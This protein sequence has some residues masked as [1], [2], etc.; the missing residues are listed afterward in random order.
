MPLFE[1][2]AVI[3]KC[4]CLYGKLLKPEDY[5]NLLKCQ[6]VSDIAVYLHDKTVYGEITGS[7]D[8]KKINR[9]KLEY[10]IKKSMLDDYLKMYRF[11]NG[12]QRHFIN[13]LMAKYEL[14]YILK[15]WREYVW[16]NAK[17]NSLTDENDEYIFSGGIIELQAIYRNRPKI[18]I[19]ALKNITTAEQF[20]KAIKNSDFFY[21][22]EKYVNEDITKNYTEIETAVYDEYYK[23]L[24]EGAESFDKE[25]K[26]KIQDAIKAQIDL[27][28]LSRISRLMFNFKTAP[29]KI[30]TLLVPVSGKLKPGDID[31]LLKSDNKENF[32]TYCEN[33]LYYAK[34]QSFYDYDSMTAYMEAYLYKY[35]KSRDISYSGFEIVVRYFELKEFE[36]KNLFYL[37]EGIRYKMPQDEIRK[38]IYG[39][40]NTASAAA[41]NSTPSA[42][43]SAE[44]RNM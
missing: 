43:A 13:L 5:E 38:Y 19:E 9:S 11:T 12:K 40:N 30:K 8:L 18:D 1:Y 15:V 39:L 16:G 25:T 34:K 3:A 17:E 14:E 7:S 32:F 2:E 44:G 42:S 31:A 33:N 35:Y 20:I 10:F 6:D 28:N 29:E 24:Y 27:K 22:F 4:R 36:L 21:I 26:I 23:I 37:I 41:S